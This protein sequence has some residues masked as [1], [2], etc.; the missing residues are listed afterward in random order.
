MTETLV[1][2][3]LIFCAYAVLE[4]VAGMIDGIKINRRRE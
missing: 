1:I 3:F 2:I 4:G